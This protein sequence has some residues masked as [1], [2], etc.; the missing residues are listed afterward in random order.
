MA[1]MRES[2]QSM[3]FKL[4]PDGVAWAKIKSSVFAKFLDAIAAELERLDGRSDSL[5]KESDPRTTIELLEDWERVA[6]LPDDCSYATTTIAQRQEALV[7][8]LTGTGSIRPAFYE[9]LAASLGYDV[10]VLEYRPFRAGRSYAGDKLTN[11]LWVFAWQVR[12]A[13]FTVKNFRAGQSFAG[14][15]LASWGN[16]LLECVLNKLRPA[17][18]KIIF[19][20]VA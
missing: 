19:T 6:G 4:A 14:E 2:Y 5:I 15:P 18:T 8:K 17:G 9:E 10:E 1:V 12:S 7:A 20:Y 13:Q 16:E 11:D 3:L